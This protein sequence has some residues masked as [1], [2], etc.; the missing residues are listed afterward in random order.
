MHVRGPLA[1]AIPRP[2]STTPTLAPG[3]T[4]ST[5]PTLEVRTPDGLPSLSWSTSWTELPRMHLAS[6]SST[7]GTA[8]RAV[9]GAVLGATTLTSGM[10]M[11]APTTISYTI[12]T[13]EAAATTH[14]FLFDADAHGDYSSTLLAANTGAVLGLGLSKAI[15]P[16]KP[17]KPA[18]VTALQTRLAERGFEVDV[19][20]KY[21]GQTDR[22]IRVFEAMITGAESVANTS[23]TV[24]PGGPIDRALAS[25]SGPRWVQMP[26]G[27]PGF[28]RVDTDHFSYGSSVAADTIRAAGQRYAT[29]YLAAHPS[30]S[31]IG[32]NDVSRRHG[33]NNEDHESHEAGLDIDVALPTTSGGH[34]TRVGASDYDRETTYAMIAAFAQDPR[35]ERILFTDRVLLRRIADSDVP[36]KHKVQDGGAGHRNHLHIDIRPAAPS[37][38]T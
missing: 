19:D 20:G 18:D 4:T 22:A 2:S 10:A 31:L 36:W 12:D 33:G 5:T 30:K 21:G 1:P 37:A 32:V 13:G 35:V 17:N 27:G 25:P 3:T 29:D 16:G 15:G 38:V 9:L 6:S 11:A 8:E 34:S 23:G 26:A 14:T 28:I 7:M 24:T